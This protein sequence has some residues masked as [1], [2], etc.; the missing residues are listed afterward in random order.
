MKKR[1][2]TRPNFSGDPREI[3]DAIGAHAANLP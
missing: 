2:K 3:A 1:R